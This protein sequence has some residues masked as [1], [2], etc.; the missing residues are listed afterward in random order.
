MVIKILFVRLFF[1]II[2]PLRR[3]YWFIFRPK[4]LGVKTLIEHDRKYLFIKNAYGLK[5]WTFPGGGVKRNEKPED[6]AKRE[7]L[8]EVNIQLPNLSYIGEYRS[9]RE[10]KRDIVY[11]YYASVKDDNY[12]LYPMEV[13]DAE[14][15]TLDK[16]PHYKSFAVDEIL[17]LYKQWKKSN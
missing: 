3:L 13:E 6:A 1:K 9:T 10:Y 2:L 12:K 16:I 8:E 11:C 15:L 14:W 4:T 7:V 17:N 5:K